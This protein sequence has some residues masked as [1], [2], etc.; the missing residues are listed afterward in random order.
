M[1]IIFLPL[2]R[3]VTSHISGCIL[4]REELSVFH[5]SNETADGGEGFETNNAVR[6]WVALKE[7]GFTEAESP[8]NGLHVARSLFVDQE[9]GN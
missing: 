7:T 3:C 4:D 6:G 9:L 8:T 1:S 2:G 5:V